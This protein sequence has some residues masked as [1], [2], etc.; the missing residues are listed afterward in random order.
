[1]NFEKGTFTEMPGCK[2]KF[3]LSSRKKIIRKTTSSSGKTSS[4]PN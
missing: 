1:M 2:I 3:E 4:H